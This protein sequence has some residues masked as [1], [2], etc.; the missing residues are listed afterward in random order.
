MP[1]GYKCS[2]FEGFEPLDGGLVCRDVDECKT[3]RPCSQHCR[4]TYGSYACSCEKGYYSIDG[5]V[6]CKA[7]STIPST[8]IFSSRYYIRQI[9]TNGFDNKLL[10]RNLT[11]AVAL[12]F[13][14]AEHC[15]YWSDVTALGSSIKRLCETYTDINRTSTEQILHSATVQ[16]PDGIAVDWIGRNLYWC[17]KGKD[18]IEVS[19]LDGKFRKIL[20]RDGLEEPRAIVL[21]PYEGFV[22]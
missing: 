10:V 16:S 1:I 7:N 15:I 18:T 2:C 9:N 22:E 5:G 20:I 17:D 8:I 3:K 14:W 6:S 12:D 4:N 21:N 11:N 13:D 19:K